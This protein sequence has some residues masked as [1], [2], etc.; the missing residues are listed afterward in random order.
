VITSGVVRQPG[1]LPGQG[2]FLAKPYT[3]SAPVQIIRGLIES[4]RIRHA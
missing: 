4:S 3:N 1:V 2:I